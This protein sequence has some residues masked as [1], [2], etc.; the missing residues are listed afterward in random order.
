MKDFVVEAIKKEI[1]DD[2]ISIRADVE[3]VQAQN[4]IEKKGAGPSLSETKAN[5]ADPFQAEQLTPI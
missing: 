4:A 1:S 2:L 3:Q 5:E